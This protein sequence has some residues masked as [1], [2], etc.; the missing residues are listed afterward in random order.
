M[1]LMTCC[2]FQHLRD[3]PSPCLCRLNQVASQIAPHSLCRALL[4]TR[5]Q[6]VLGCNLGLPKADCRDDRLVLLR[7]ILVLAWGAMDHEHSR[8]LN[9]S[10]SPTQSIVWRMTCSVR[11][12]NQDRHVYFVPVFACHI[13]G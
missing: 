1:S 6:K 11:V 10:Q 9:G 5:A 13:V 3:D 7:Y 2:S 8:C 4:L 12:N